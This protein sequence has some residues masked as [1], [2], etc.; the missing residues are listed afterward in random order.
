MR[1]V[2]CQFFF[3]DAEGFAH[4]DDLM[5]RQGTG[6]ETAF[7]AATVHL[8]FEADAG[9]AADVQCADAFR[10]VHFMTG[11]GQQVDFGCFYV[12]RHFAAC[13]CCVNVEND[14]AFAADFADGGN[15]LN[16]ADFVVYPHDGNEDGVFTDGGFQYV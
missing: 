11:H 14:F 16:H 2:L 10:T 7:V 8:G 15:V 3:G 12:N 9:F 1:S 4:A 13:L 6:T 5:G